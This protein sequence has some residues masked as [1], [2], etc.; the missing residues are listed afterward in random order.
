MLTSMNDYMINLIQSPWTS[1]VYRELLT[2]G[3]GEQA[4]G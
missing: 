1:H 3:D 2:N 4:H